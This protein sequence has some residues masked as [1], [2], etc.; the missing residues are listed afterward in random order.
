MAGRGIYFTALG[1]GVLLFWSGFKGWGIVSTIQDIITGKQP[2]GPAVNVPVN[3]PAVTSPSGP[4]AVS[5]NALTSQATGATAGS[6]GST[7]QIAGDGLLYVGHAYR[8]GGAPG[9]NGTQPWD[10]SSFVN[11]VISHDLGLAWPGAGRYDGASHG[12]P[13]G[14]WGAWFIARGMT[15]KGGLANAQAGD[16]VVWANHM[17]IAVGGG[18]MVSALNASEGTK[19]TGWAPNGPLLCVGR[20]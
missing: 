12:P 20:Y 11:W 13:T 4:V 9:K 2:S 3:P 15:V 17:G 8:Y 5:Q 10:C 1:A 18:Q 6:R 14:S 7:N 19:V 16:V